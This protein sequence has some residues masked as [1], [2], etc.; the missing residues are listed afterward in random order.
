[1]HVLPTVGPQ[2]PS[3]EIVKGVAFAV[4]L[5][6]VED[7]EDD[8]LVLEPGLVLVE[9]E[10][11]LLVLVE[12]VEVDLLV[13]EPGLVVD[14]EEPGL[15]VLVDLLVLEPGLV[16]VEEPGLLVLEPG[17]VDVEEPGLLVL[18][19][20][21]DVEEPGLVD[22]TVLEPQEPEAELHPVPQ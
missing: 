1:M 5:E 11:D 10:D 17:L 22:D 8:L 18:E 2:V 15:L 16:D 7:V 13:L 20:G 4:A 3:R 9:M 21:L 19:P 12:E 14:V 6:D